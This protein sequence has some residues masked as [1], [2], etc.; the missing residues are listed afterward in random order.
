VETADYD[1]FCSSTAVYPRANDAEVGG[2]LMYCSLGLAGE[3]G[4]VMNKMLDT[5]NLDTGEVG[6]CL[7]YLA[8]L[9]AHCGTSLDELSKPEHL[10]MRLVAETGEVANKV[11]KL[12]R[13]GE[14][15]TAKVVDLIEQCLGT[16]SRMHDLN[17]L[18][19]K[20]AAK[21][22]SRKDRGALRG[23]GDER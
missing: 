11:K 14:L 13:D 21:L 8:R 20:N 1:E 17:D 18:M 16:I 15:Q 6:D 9:A 2:P 7:W 19:E 10:V 12:Y 3:A 23:S 22:Q 4:E 5:K